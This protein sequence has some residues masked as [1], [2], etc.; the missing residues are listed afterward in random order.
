MSLASPRHFQHFLSLVA[1]NGLIVS[2]IALFMPLYFDKLGLTGVHT[3]AY[4][5]L[6]SVAS[7]L[8]A[9]PAGISTDRMS[10]VKILVF[11]LLLGAIHKVGF[12]LGGVFQ[13][14]MC[15]PNLWAS[16]AFR[17]VH[18]I[19]DG[20]VFLVYYQGIAKVFKLDRIGGCAAFVSLWTALGALLGALLYGW[21]GGRWGAH[22]PLIVSGCVLAV[23]PLLLRLGDAGLER[24]YAPVGGSAPS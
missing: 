7:V 6:L 3:G 23:T 2:T 9:L 5:A 14:L 19:G 12:L 11:A 24:E 13:V 15:V 1:A 17:C 16:F 20:L 21:M 8:L 4:F 22:W 18:E 10:I